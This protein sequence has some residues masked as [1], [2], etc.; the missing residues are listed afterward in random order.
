[1]VA[2]INEANVSFRELL[3]V[4]SALTG[5]LIGGVIA[6]LRTF[7]AAARERK[8]ALRIL[9]YALLQ[10]RFEI[11]RYNPDQFMQALSRSFARRFGVDVAK[12]LEAP[13]AK[14]FFDGII[15]KVLDEM[16]TD[17]NPK[18]NK[19]V[20]AL[21]PHDPILAYCLV[22]NERILALDRILRQYCENLRAN[23][24]IA[25]DPAGIRFLDSSKTTMLNTALVEAKKQLAED[26]AHVAWELSFLTHLRVKDALSRQDRV[27]EKELDEFL[28]QVFDSILDGIPRP[29]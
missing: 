6:E 29:T 10:I 23:P 12:E 27:L 15:Q 17:L 26:I 11:C 13:E 3:P 20:E 9:L 1:M 25:A 19:A 24:E 18:Y 7:M 4:I 14:A 16:R 5:A 8:K 22:G 21:S 28:D 2:P